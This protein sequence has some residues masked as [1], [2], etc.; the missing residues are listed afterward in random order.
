MLNFVSGDISIM[1]PVYIEI[2]RRS[3]LLIRFIYSQVRD[4]AVKK[5]VRHC[6]LITT[7]ALANCPLITDVS[8]AEIATNL[9]RIR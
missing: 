3:E 6:P 2:V 5:I 8:L 9:P 7:L 1:V 4:S